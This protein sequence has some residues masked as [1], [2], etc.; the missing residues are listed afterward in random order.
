MIK[1]ICD[2][3]GKEIEKELFF[4]INVA[5]PDI[6]KWCEEE[7]FSHVYRHCIE[8]GITIN[9]NGIMREKKDEK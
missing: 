1:I 6:H 4:T 3:C 9:N 5:I 7:S 2:N 8:Y